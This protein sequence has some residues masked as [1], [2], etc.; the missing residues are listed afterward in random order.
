MTFVFWVLSLKQTFSLSTFT[1]IKRL[2]S[3]SLLS[4]IKLVS[5]A[6]LR[7]LIF[8]LAIFIAAYTSSSLAFHMMY[9]AYKLNKKGNDI[10]PWCTP[11]PIW[12][13]SVPCPVLIVASWP[14]YM[15]KLLCLWNSP[16]K[17]TRVCSHSLFQGIFLT[18]GLNPGLPHCRQILHHLSHQGSLSISYM[19]FKKYK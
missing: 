12:S 6:Y 10:Q 14:A 3:S 9:F 11:F 7:L 4:V 18:Q 17:N 1:F 8:F 2:F 16:G 19:Q 5:S 15:S 13:H